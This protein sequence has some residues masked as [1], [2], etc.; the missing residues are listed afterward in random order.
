MSVSSNLTKRDLKQLLKTSGGA[1][2]AVHALGSSAL[3]QEKRPGPG[4]CNSWAKRN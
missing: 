1:F 4:T 3:G 2:I